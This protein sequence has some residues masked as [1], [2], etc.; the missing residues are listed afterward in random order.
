VKRTPQESGDRVPL[1]ITIA[2]FVVLLA[3][4]PLVLM[5]DKGIDS[6]R[7]MYHDM[8]DMLR[9]QATYI[10]TG[11]PPVEVQ[12]SDGQSTKI[13]ETTFTVSDGV[14]LTVRATQ[15]DAFCVTASNKEGAT[16]ER[17]SDQ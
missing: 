1:L 5:L 16:S 12:L 4:L 9:L 6:D 17:C 11:Q 8:D 2:V 14:T 7:P 3:C 15:D 13:G 10:A